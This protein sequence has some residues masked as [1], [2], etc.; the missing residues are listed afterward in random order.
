MGPARKVIIHNLFR[1]GQLRRLYATTTIDPALYGKG[2]AIESCA[3][4]PI[5][6]SYQVA[7][8]TLREYFG[9]PHV[10]VD[11]Q[12]KELLH[13]PSLR[14]TDGPSIVEFSRHLHT[15]IEPSLKWAPNTWLI[16]IT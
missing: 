13:L 16:L 8:E 14:N 12:I 11:T 15:L 5:S 2:E 3:N 4:L 6:E 1:K 7:K 9:K 10:I